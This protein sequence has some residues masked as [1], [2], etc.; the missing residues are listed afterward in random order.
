VPGLQPI[1]SFLMEALQPKRGLPVSPT[2]PVLP[3]SKV[4]QLW[5]ILG[6]GGGGW[7]RG[8]QHG[9]WQSVGVANRRA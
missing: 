3:T 9:V 5:G 2:V 1:S 8:Q 6:G 7:G 4:P